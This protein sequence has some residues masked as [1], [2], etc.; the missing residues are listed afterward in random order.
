V[1]TDISARLAER[2]RLEGL[3]IPDSVAAKL[4]VYLEVLLHW[5]RKINLTSLTEPD[6]TI[7]RLLLEPIAAARYLPAGG[8]LVDFGSGGGSPA[9]PLALALG[10]ATLVMIESRTRKAAFLREAVREIGVPATVETGRFEEVAADEQYRH[11]FEVVSIRAVRQDATTL[12]AAAALL[13]AAGV[14]ALFR[15]P[16]GPDKVSLPPEVP[17]RWDQTVPL[18]RST[19]SRLSS[20]FHVEHS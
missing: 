12:S 1:L 20:L 16:E 13:R 15:G 2:S 9:V 10:T 4:V 17:L 7:D 11:W 19:R 6:E 18:L 3:L 8:R 5:N 14:V